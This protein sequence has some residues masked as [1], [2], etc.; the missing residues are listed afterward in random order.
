MGTA[1][2]VQSYPRFVNTGLTY[3]QGIKGWLFESPQEDVL[4]NTT[5]QGV[6]TTHDTSTTSDVSFSLFTLPKSKSN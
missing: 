4:V 3:M 5:L 1:T 6:T 2:K